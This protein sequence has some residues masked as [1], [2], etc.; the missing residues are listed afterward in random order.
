LGLYKKGPVVLA[1]QANAKIIPMIVRGSRDCLPYGE[2]KIRPGKVTVKVLK[3]ISTEGMEYEDRDF[4]VNE[5]R[6]LAERELKLR[7]SASDDSEVY[8]V[9]V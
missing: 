1:I 5:L 2:W 4:L 9:E 6:K 7:V 8:R 3:E